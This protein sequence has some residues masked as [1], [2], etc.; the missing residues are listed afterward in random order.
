[1][2]HQTLEQLEAR[3]DRLKEQ[4]NDI[5]ARIAEARKSH[6]ARIA[7]RYA[8]AFEQAG[9]QLPEPEALL[10]AIASSKRKP[11]KRKAAAA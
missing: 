3:R 1:M 9:E 4:L 11:R 8:K 2:S 7:R 5:T 10:K 6:F